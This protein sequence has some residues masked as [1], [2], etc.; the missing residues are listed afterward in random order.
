[1][2]PRSKKM[3][4]HRLAGDAKFPTS[5]YY[6]VLMRIFDYSG[7]TGLRAHP[8]TQRL[9]EECQLSVSTVKTALKWLTQEGWLRLGQRGGRAGDGAHW[10]SVYEL[11][12]PRGIPNPLDDAKARDAWDTYVADDDVRYDVRG[13][14]C[15]APENDPWEVAPQPRERA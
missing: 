6:R 13:N 7:P 2:N 15:V 8:G 1:M 9:A 11:S 4:W 14:P 5:S 12:T 10:A 3:V